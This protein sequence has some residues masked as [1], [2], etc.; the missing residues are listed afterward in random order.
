MGSDA[1]LVIVDM[2]KESVL[3]AD[4]MYT[5]CGWNPYAGRKV[6]G[7]PEMTLVRGTVVSE[8]FGNVVGKPGFGDYVTPNVV[9]PSDE[10][11]PSGKKDIKAP[12][13]QS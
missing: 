11:D 4:K 2:K 12:P 1:D 3:S 5:R 9:P 8:N 10:Y 7:M 6:K 13:L